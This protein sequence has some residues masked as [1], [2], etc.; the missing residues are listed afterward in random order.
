MAV[1]A[2]TEVTGAPDGPGALSVVCY[3]TAD[4][5]APLWTNKQH[6]MA[7]LGASG[8]PVLYI[9]S[10]GLRAPGLGRADLTRMARRVADWRPHA[11]TCA[12]NVVRD[13]PLVVPLHR[14]AAV[15]ALNRW[16]LERRLRRNETRYGLHRPVIWAYQPSGADA[17]DPGRHRALVY[18][19][20]DDLAG[21]PGID[22]E[23][24]RAGEARLVARADVCIASSRPLQRHLERLGARTALYWP[25]PADT[26]AYRAA[27]ERAGPRAGTAPVIGFVGAVAE[28]KVDFALLREVARRRPGWRL[29]LVGPLGAGLA[30]SEVDPATFPPNVEFWGLRTREELPGVVAGFDVGMVPYLRNEYT[31]GVFP[32]KVFEYLGAG[33]PVVATPLPSLVGEVA[34]VAFAEDADAWITAVEAALAGGDDGRAVRRDHAE[35]FSWDN[36]TREALDLLARL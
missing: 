16:L 13:S 18:H 5:D 12:P 2:R 25:N 28:H 33:L 30:S 27:A 8:V 15:R 26:G 23:T 6:L 35:A 20:V 4:W 17:Y 31:A 14:Y 11:R 36:R 21:Y 9:D 34:H 7:R 32:M 3:S 22:R 1:A 10:L 29:R 19:C 24:W